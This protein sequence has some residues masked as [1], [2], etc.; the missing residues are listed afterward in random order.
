VIGEISRQTGH[1]RPLIDIADIAAD[2][3]RTLGSFVLPPAIEAA[4]GQLRAA[5]LIVIG[6]P[7]LQGFLPG[8]LQALSRPPRP[9]GP[10]GQVGDPGG[11]RRQRPARADP[12]TPAAR[13]TSYLGLYS[14]PKTLFAR[15]TDFS[16]YR[17]ASPA[18]AERVALVAGQARRLL[19]TPAAHGLA[20]RPDAFIHPRRSP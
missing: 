3:G 4:H 15:D 7:V 10:R 8:R 14:A 9:Q 12:R 17:L 13:L 18:I 11:H 19:R 5:D 2:L 6:V 20:E 16:D 1:G